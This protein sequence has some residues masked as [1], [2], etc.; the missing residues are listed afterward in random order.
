[1]G[2]LNHRTLLLDATYRP[3]RVISWM[4]AVVLEF[5]NKVMVVETYDECARSQND[6]WPLPAVVALKRF[7]G[8]RP[9]KVR[10]TKRN[11]STH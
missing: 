1:M 4:R 5:Q 2:T 10:F 8:Y 6:E 11:Y 7:H 9:F 3:I